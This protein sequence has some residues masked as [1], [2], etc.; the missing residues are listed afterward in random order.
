M[1]EPAGTVVAALVVPHSPTL[2]EAE[3]E[4]TETPVMTALRAVGARLRDLGTEAVVGVTT[5]WQPKGGFALDPADRH[6]PA[7]DPVGSLPTVPYGC[8]GDPTLAEALLE[9]AR[10]AGI[11]VA[12]ETRGIDQSLAVPLHFLA[13]DGDLPVVPLA[14]SRRPHDACLAWGMAV[15]QGVAASGRKVAIL[16]P[17]VFAHNL[18]ALI[19]HLHRPE[20]AEFEQ[21]VIGHLERGRGPE[22]AGLDARLRL[23]CQ[24]DAD[25]RDLFILLGAVGPG[26]PA[27]LLAYEPQPG[28]GVGV[29]AFNLETR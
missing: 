17:G 27:K 29:L 14:A 28:M 4:G 16:A 5:H 25:F 3:A 13:P 9:A 12:A 26:T 23:V 2:L 7:K 19:H 18:G 22:L 8:P 24:P 21:A 20:F 6:E 1:V 10:G 15:A 11:E